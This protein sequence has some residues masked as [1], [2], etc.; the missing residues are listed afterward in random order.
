MVDGS[1]SSRMSTSTCIQYLQVEVRSL[2]LA[3]KPV[4]LSPARIAVSL[5]SSTSSRRFGLWGV[6]FWPS[7]EISSTWSSPLLI[8][9]PLPSRRRSKT[10]WSYLSSKDNC[11]LLYAKA[12]SPRLPPTAL[13]A[14]AA[15]GD[16]RTLTRQALGLALALGAEDVPRAAPGGDEVVDVAHVVLGLAHVGEPGAAGALG[17]APDDLDAEDV[18]AVD[19]VPH[20]DAELGE[21]VAQQDGAVD[22]GAPDGQ[23]HAGEGLAAPRRH[24][25]HVARLRRVPVRAREE[26]RAQALGVQAPHL[27][28]VVGGQRRRGH[29]PGGGHARVD[30]EGGA[31]G[32]RGIPR[33]ERVWRVMCISVILIRGRRE[34]DGERDVYIY[35]ERESLWEKT[36]AYMVWAAAVLSV[37]VSLSVSISLLVREE[38]LRRTRSWVSSRLPLCVIMASDVAGEHAVARP[39]RRPAAAGWVV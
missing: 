8:S 11:L 6:V 14:P 16:T 34:R 22:A 20:L 3:T 1:N 26:R 9:L 25:Q 4:R 32:D 17:A 19:L 31:D 28:R 30:G 18:G 27:L 29:G 36:Y 38:A 39:S 5:D 13:P 2:S 24:L 37:S 21:G 7:H 35:R 15:G 10:T 23:A 12:P 33:L